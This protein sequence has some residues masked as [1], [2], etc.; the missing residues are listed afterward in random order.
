MQAKL[1]KEVEINEGEQELDFDVSNLKLFTYILSIKG[2]NTD[3]FFKIIK[4]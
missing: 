2:V 3:T 4:E 1:I